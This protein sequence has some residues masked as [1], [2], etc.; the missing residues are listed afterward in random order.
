MDIW[1]SNDLQG[2]YQSSSQNVGQINRNSSILGNHLYELAKNNQYKTYLE[3]GTWNGLGSTRCFIE[4]FNDRDSDDYIFWSLESNCEKSNFA[5]LLYKSEK[6]VYI[7]NE[8]LFNNMPE[9]ILSIF[10]EIEI[11][12]NFKD[13]LNIDAKNMSDK[14]IFLERPNLPDVFDVVFLDGGEFTT[15]YEFQKLKDRCRIIVLDDT[16]VSKCKKIVEVL[17]SETNSWKIIEENNERNGFLI[18]VSLLR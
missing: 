8:V 9:D 16:N 6:N 11:N 15:W 12:S 2:F 13:W 17:K 4:G 1:C 3:I 14:K 5:K 10:P 7:L 18:A